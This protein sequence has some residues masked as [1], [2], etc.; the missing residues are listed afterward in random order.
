VAATDEQSQQEEE[1][2]KL[3]TNYQILSRL[4]DLQA[5]NPETEA[6]ETFQKKADPTQ[7]GSVE[8]IVKAFEKSDVMRDVRKEKRMERKQQ[9]KADHDQLR[10]HLT[11]VG[12]VK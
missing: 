1:K 10:Q 6:W 4:A 7:G 11:V 3:E 8:Y 2:R 12:R 5:K 9:R